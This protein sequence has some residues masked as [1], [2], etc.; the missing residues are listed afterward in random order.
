MEIPSRSTYQGENQPYG[1]VEY[2][3]LENLYPSGHPYHHSTIGSMADLSSASLADVKKWFKDHYGPNNA[4]LVLA[5][6]LMLAVAAGVL[7]SRMGGEFLPKLGEQA[8]AVSTVRL[9]GVSLDEPGRL[10]GPGLR[11]H[12]LSGCAGACGHGN[13]EDQ[14]NDWTQ[15][16][17]S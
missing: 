14:G 13:S 9:A 1:L 15:R 8:L 3:Q 5:G 12:R 6:A 17:P 10:A 4:I 2:E 11:A 7:A 16:L